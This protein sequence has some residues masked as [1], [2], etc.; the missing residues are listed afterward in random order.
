MQGSLN[1][2]V[3]TQKTCLTVTKQRNYN[4]TCSNLLG[5]QLFSYHPA[6]SG[7]A[8]LLVMRSTKSHL[9]GETAVPISP[10]MLQ[11]SVIS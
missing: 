11:S 6:N 7:V 5:A 8:L 10:S 2:L 9:G 1:Y 3:R 4:K